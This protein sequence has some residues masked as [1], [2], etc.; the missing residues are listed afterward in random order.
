V[1]NLGQ[2]NF[3]L[4]G[5]SNIT[6]VIQQSPDLINWTPVATN[7][8]PSSIQPISVSPPDTQDFYRAVASP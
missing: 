2:L 5:Q 3:T 4:T 7:F 8:S 6:Y 1:A